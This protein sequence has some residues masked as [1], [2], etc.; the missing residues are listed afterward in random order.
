MRG[1]DLASVVLVW[2]QGS[3]RTHPVDMTPAI[4]DSY[5]ATMGPVVGTEPVTWHVVATD[6]AENRT[7]SET[8]TLP[9]RGAC[10]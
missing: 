5:T 8:Q 6:T 9:V 1:D 7:V 10:G 2:Q 3:G 4:G